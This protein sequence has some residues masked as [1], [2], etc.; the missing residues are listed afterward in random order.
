MSVLLPRLQSS[1]SHQLTRVTCKLLRQHSKTSGARL[2][3]TRMGE[4]RLKPQSC[5]KFVINTFNCSRNFVRRE[6]LKPR[7]IEHF[8]VWNSTLLTNHAVQLLLCFFFYLAW[9]LNLSGLAYL[10]L[11]V[12]W[13][14]AD[15][16]FLY[17][18]ENT[19][20]SK[21]GQA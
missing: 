17:V 18:C 2:Q 11:Q 5:F 3:Q 19:I 10:K 20:L 12:H 8:R 21:F 7:N 13:F 1:I 16:S 4:I 9:E 6:K 14:T 15:G